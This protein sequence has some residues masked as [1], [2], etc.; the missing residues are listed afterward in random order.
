MD[1]LSDSDIVNSLLKTKGGMGGGGGGGEGET[2]DLI[3]LI[4]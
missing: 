3:M 2:E 4:L 1:F